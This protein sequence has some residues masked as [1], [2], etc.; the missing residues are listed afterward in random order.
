METVRLTMAQALVQFLDQQYIELDGQEYKFVNNMFG[1][2]GHGCVVGVGQA[3]NQGGHHI[4]FL[5]GKNEQNMALAAG[6]AAISQMQQS[7][8][9]GSFYR[10][11]F[12]TRDG[13]FLKEHLW[14]MEPDSVYFGDKK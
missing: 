6:K 5:Q 14:V 8:L 11:T 4:R 10:V 1:V 3:L 13:V 9:V 12:Y 7:P 2:F